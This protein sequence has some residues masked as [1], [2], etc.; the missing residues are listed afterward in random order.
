[1]GSS[2]KTSKRIY[3]KMNEIKGVISFQT[4]IIIKTSDPCKNMLSTNMK[5]IEPYDL[6][7]ENHMQPKEKCLKNNLI[8]HVCQQVDKCASYEKWK[9]LMMNKKLLWMIFYTRKTKIQQNHY[10]FF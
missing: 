10:M 7:F 4:K 6:M 1:M 9:N 3:T 5:E 8:I 2:K